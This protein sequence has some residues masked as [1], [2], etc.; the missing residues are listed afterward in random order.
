MDD[1]FGPVTIHLHFPAPAPRYLTFF[2]PTNAL[3]LFRA[4]FSIIGVEDC[5]STVLVP[6]LLW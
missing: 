3:N 4:G 5:R 1:Q 2:F 6:P